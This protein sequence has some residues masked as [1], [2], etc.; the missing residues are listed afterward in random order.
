MYAPPCLAALKV[1]AVWLWDLH[2]SGA[3]SPMCPSSHSHL[4]KH[5]SSISHSPTTTVSLSLPLSHSPGLSSPDKSRTSLQFYSRD[6]EQ[7]QNWR[8]PGL[9]SSSTLTDVTSVSLGRILATQSHDC[10]ICEVGESRNPLVWSEG[11]VSE[12]SWP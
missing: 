8:S 9:N 6:T 7:S 11:Q 4:L 3:P 1:F 2:H 5:T 12:Q 10:P